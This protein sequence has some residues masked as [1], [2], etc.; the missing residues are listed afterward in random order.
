[1]ILMEN[2]I[3]EIE[4]IEKAFM[5]KK[6]FFRAVA[7]N[8]VPAASAALAERPLQ[9]ADGTPLPQPPGE[10]PGRSPALRA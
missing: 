2:G 9:A 7:E 3:A 5:G 4:S 10:K 1:L 6:L 8:R